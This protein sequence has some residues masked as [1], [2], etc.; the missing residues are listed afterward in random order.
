M[1]RI[2]ILLAICPWSLCAHPCPFD[3]NIGF[4]NDTEIKGADL[5]DFVVNFNEAAKKETKGRIARAIIY[6]AKSDTL[7]KVPQDSPFAKEM[8]ELFRRYAEVMEP[9]RKKGLGDA[10]PIAIGFPAKFPV[11]CLLSAQFHGG[12]TDYEET[13]EGARVTRRRA[14]L[15]CRAY[16]LSDK[17]L[18][19]VREWQREDRIPAG[20]QPES[21]IFAEFSGMDWAFDTD[22]EAALDFVQEPFIDGVTRFIPGKRVVLAIE[23]KEK[24]EEMAKEMAERGLLTAPGREG[25]DA[26][27]QDAKQDVDGNPE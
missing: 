5:S 17:F 23:T 18:E 12:W 15:E 21:Y 6:D 8:D 13:K 19:T 24:H 3:W 25:F 20:E 27:T 2:A 26:N 10:A 22:S 9:L 7:R 11:A 14:V 1:N 16:H 4:A